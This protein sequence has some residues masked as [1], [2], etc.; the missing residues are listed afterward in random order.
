MNEYAGY[1]HPVPSGWWAM[2]RFARDG[3]PKPIMG[4]GDKPIVFPTETEALR[5]INRHLLRYFN[6]QYLRDGAKAERFLAADAIFSL[7]P[8]RR[9]GKVI[10][11]AQRRDRA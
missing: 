11:V 3:K 7:K 9:G 5:E 2:L 10:E 1:P 4:D 6:G 8:I